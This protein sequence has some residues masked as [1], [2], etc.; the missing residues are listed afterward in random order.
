V[1]TANTTPAQPSI[2]PIGPTTFCTGG[3]V[4][5]I[6]SAATGNQWYLDGNPL[7]GVT[8]QFYA[9]GADGDYTVIATASGCS[10]A[11]SSAQPVTVNPSPAVTADPVGSSICAYNSGS[12]SVT[13]TDAT[14]YQWQESSDGGGS[15][16]NITD[17]GVYSGTGTS[18]LTITH[19]PFS[20]SGYQYRCVVS[21]GCAP[22]ATSAAATM[23][24][25]GPQFTQQPTDESVCENSDATFS[26]TVSSPGFPSYQWF[27]STDN[28]LNFDPVPSAAPYSGEFTSELTI[29]G[30]TVGMDGYLYRAKLGNGLCA[31]LSPPSNSGELSV[32]PATTWYA[33][34]DG[35]GYGDPNSTTTA[36]T[37]P[38][39]YS[40]SPCGSPTGLSSSNVLDTRATVQWT[41]GTGA[42]N[43]QVRYRPLGGGAWGI[44]SQSM[45]DVDR[46]LNGLSPSTTYVWEARSRCSTD[47]GD[48][49][50]F[51][52]GAQFTTAASCGTATGLASSNVTDETAKLTWTAVPSAAEYKVRYRV[53]GSG[54]WTTRTV[55]APTVQ[56]NLTGLSDATT[57]EY[58]I[59]TTC[60][61]GT[62]SESSVGTFT[63]L[64][65]CP[66]I[67][68][69]S[70]S[71]ITATTVRVNWATEPDAASYTV[72]YGVQ[73]SG[74]WS[75]TTAN[76]P[77]LLRNISGLAPSTTY[78]YYVRTN[79]TNGL[80]ELGELRTFT[81]ASA[82]YAS[83]DANDA[84][85][86]RIYPNPTQGMFRIEPLTEFDGA[87][88]VR[89]TDMTGRALLSRT[90]AAAEE[91]AIELGTGLAMGTYILTITADGQVWNERVVVTE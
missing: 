21:G 53:Q 88:D 40:A 56:R 15:F 90:W 54:T 43:S 6:S 32:D 7:S 59:G 74:T 37:Q 46:N 13:A 23:T 87:A 73:G 75:A 60:T 85:T 70:V 17:G 65:A 66:A 71:N 86:F 12:Y 19:P 33:D 4:I 30:A 8:A 52:I 31:I 14:G 55:A 89:L 20:M 38:L 9:A 39:G 82:R 61:A 57:Y 26:V 45:P 44:V 84:F 58:M 72:R 28:G 35:N 34:P 10:S 3:S 24:V 67:T 79:C 11:A 2:T 16:G 47:A 51:V 29:T 78:E 36:C 83:P 81:T 41:A 69:V 1:V 5:L 64:S 48:T 27:Y 76:A 50:V 22:N 77:A 62:Y 80:S 68:G 42:T 18:L 91:G 63:T 49:S 25:I